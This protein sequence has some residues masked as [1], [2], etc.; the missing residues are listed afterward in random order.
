MEKLIAY[1]EGRC[2]EL[3][4]L[5]RESEELREPAPTWLIEAQINAALYNEN[6]TTH[7]N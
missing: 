2:G 4:Q 6:K 1:F 3:K 7:S 5:I